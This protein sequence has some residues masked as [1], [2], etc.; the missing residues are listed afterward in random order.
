MEPKE[1]HAAKKEIPNSSGEMIVKPR[2]W[3]FLSVGF[4]LVVLLVILSY[5]GWVRLS[6][7]DSGLGSNFIAP[8][9]G[10]MFAALN[11]QGD[12]L[13]NHLTFTLLATFWGGI[14][15]WCI[16]LMIGFWVRWIKIPDSGF[17]PTVAGLLFAVAAPAPYLVIFFGIGFGF[18]FILCTLFS[19]PGAMLA[20]RAT[21]ERFLI[22]S[23][24]ALRT[25]LS[26]AFVGAFFA[27]FLA[28][29]IGL[30]Y[31]ILSSS[32]RMSIDL[33]LGVY[34]VSVFVLFLIHGLLA[35][36]EFIFL[37]RPA[38]ASKQ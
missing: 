5:P 11:S 30:G 2:T 1:G 15:G 4:L 38:P 20:F 12:K 32:A 23:I 17:L 3:T 22:V 31:L 35:L 16:A 29:D 36:A 21:D 19:I 9:V 27:E 7:S 26:L 37:G 18:E 6:T 24:R 34:L 10:Q 14:F 13:L 8:S 25:G 28:S 33:L